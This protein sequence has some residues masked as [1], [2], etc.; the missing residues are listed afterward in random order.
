M[1]LVCSVII[2]E[3]SDRS[4]ARDRSF[5]SKRRTTPCAPTATR[6]TKSNTSPSLVDARGAGGGGILCSCASFNQAASSARDLEW[7]G[8]GSCQMSVRGDQEGCG[9]EGGECPYWNLKSKAW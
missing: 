5:R 4:S 3:G 2:C 1:T 6:H 7:E 9:V 8:D